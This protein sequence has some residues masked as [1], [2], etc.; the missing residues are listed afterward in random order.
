MH[1]GAPL[2]PIAQRAASK[3]VEDGQHLGEGTPF[4]GQHDAGA[5]YDHPVGLGLL[6]S[7]LPVPA[8]LSQVVLP[9][10]AA[11]IEGLVL[12]V[13]VVSCMHANTFNSSLVLADYWL[14][15]LIVLE[16]TIKSIYIYLI[17]STT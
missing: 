16:I 9:A 14:I 1:P 17:M 5:H 4:L 6:C 3:D 10:V 12:A 2:L 11:F 7:S 8:D 15:Q 13:A